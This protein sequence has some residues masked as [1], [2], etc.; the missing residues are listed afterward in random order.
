MKETGAVLANSMLAPE[1][2]N[3]LRYYRAKIYLDKKR[4]DAAIEDL[5]QLSGDTRNVYGAEAKYLLAQLYYNTGNYDKAEQEILDY[6]NVSTPHS[7]WLARSF[8]L[9]SDVYVKKEKNIEAKQYLLSL[10]Q[11]YHADDDIASMVET[12]LKALEQHQ[13]QQ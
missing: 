9:L 2:S 5:K 4:N 10:K 11:S 3:E 13:T 1:T 7:Y 8:V 6:I 12:R